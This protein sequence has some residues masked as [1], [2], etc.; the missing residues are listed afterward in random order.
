MTNL[1]PLSQEIMND[2]ARLT[3]LFPASG[4]P[5]R[6]LWTDAFAVCN[7]LGLHQETGDGKFKDMALQLVGQVHSTLGRY[8]QDDKRAGWISGLDGEEAT[9]HPT[10][11]GLRIGKQFKERS[12]TEPLNERLE[13]DRD[14]QYFH[15]LTKWMHAL[16]RVTRVTGEFTYNR[17]AIELA[18]ISH[19][20]FVYAP[21]AGKQ[22]RM[23]W[24]MSTN[25]SYPLVQSMGLHDPLDGLITYTQLA[26]TAAGDAER[27]AD[28][29]TEI[30]DMAGMAKGRG[31]VTDDPLGIGSLLSNAL[32]VA[33]LM[34]AGYF[35]QSGLLVILLEASLLGLKAFDLD[36][37]NLPADHRL[38]FREL[39]LSIGLRAFQGLSDLIGRNKPLFGE[40]HG[41][42]GLITALRS[43]ERLAETIETFWLQPEHQQGD[44]WMTHRHINMVMLATSISPA[45]YLTL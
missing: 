1:T 14:G 44:L 27:S 7:L 24:K 22:K 13:W 5:Q 40:E 20:R 39:G 29:K 42:D 32:S 18:R 38:A 3:G 8:R 25:L 23:Y 36:R 9:L 45:G 33:Q 28:L 34:T 4:V 19:A 35:S 26:A 31:W 15:Y 30:A 37:I 10:A 12:S 41:L 17:W 16:N 11:G 43:Y 21:S 6:Y 2:F